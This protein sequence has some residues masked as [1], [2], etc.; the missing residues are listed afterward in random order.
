MTDFAN[1]SV[2]AFTAALKQG[3]EARA[4]LKTVSVSDGPAAPA[5][6]EREE[7]VQ[8]LDVEGEWQVHS[9]SR[10][11]Q[12]RLEVQTLTVQITVQRATREKQ[13]QVNARAFEIFNE[14]NQLL[15]DPDAGVT[16]LY[17]GPGRVYG[18]RITAF[19]HTKRVSPDNMTREAGLEVGV[20]WEAKI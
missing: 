19:K 10:P 2:L 17:T 16:S 14:L 11:T 13:T 3:L 15:R 18:P 12:P 6:M 7:L 9:I 4:A 1:S 5:D 8:L 20:H